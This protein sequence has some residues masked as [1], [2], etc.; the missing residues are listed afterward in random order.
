[1]SAKHIWTIIKK[2]LN[3]WPTLRQIAE[4]KMTNT[5]SFS[6]FVWTS[7]LLPDANQLSQPISVHKEKQVLKIDY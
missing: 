4:E 1:M 3:N 2:L 6:E 7:D 5:N